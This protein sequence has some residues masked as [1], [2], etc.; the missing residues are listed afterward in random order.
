MLRK[1]LI[2][3]IAVFALQS[4]GRDS[5]LVNVI[6]EESFCGSVEVAREGK[7]V[8]SQGFG[9]ADREKK[10]VNT[11]E[12]Q[13]LI[14]SITKVFTA[15][16]ILKLVE[17]GKIQESLP[18]I[19]YLKSDD[20]MWS[21]RVPA[22]AHEVTIHH[23]LTHSSGL[24]DYVTLPGFEEFYQQSH[25]TK[26][27]IQF[28]AYYP[29]KFQPGTQFEYSGSGYNLLGA[30]IERIA[31]QSYGEYLKVEFFEPL[32]MVS[33]FAP[34]TAFLSKIQQEHPLLAKGYRFDKGELLPAGEVN[35]TTAFSEASIISTVKDLLIWTE[36]LFGGKI[37]SKASLEKMLTPYFETETKDVWVGYGIFIDQENPS[38]PIYSH[39]GRINGYDSDWKYEPKNGISVILLSNEMGG[40]TFQLADKLLH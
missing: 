15:A 38:I 39:T 11:S 2:F 25:T 10:I 24:V 7:S 9:Y 21:G 13:Y 27:L 12:T 17:Q 31:D 6:R 1:I 34:Q 40:S 19:T 14:G 20:P 33:T 37:L 8:V 3:L 30:I 23:L 5:R 16:A 36:G 32:G 26:E 4:C 28:F 29:L 18:I 35:M 22:W